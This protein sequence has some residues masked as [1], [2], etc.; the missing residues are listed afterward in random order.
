MI[1][2]KSTNVTICDRVFTIGC[3]YQEQFVPSRGHVTSLNTS[4]NKLAG[5]ILFDNVVTGVSKMS[6]K[7]GSPLVSCQVRI[8][9]SMGFK[10]NIDQLQCTC[11]F[12][13]REVLEV[14]C[15]IK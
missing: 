5:L 10:R 12:Y 3:P 14:H 6:A 15:S 11:V 1:F 8:R 13:S 2:G 9:A 4:T 7:I